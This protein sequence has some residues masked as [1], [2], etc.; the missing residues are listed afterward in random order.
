M[1]NGDDSG[2]DDSNSS[3]SDSDS[4]SDGDGSDSVDTAKDSASD[5]DDGDPGSAQ[6]LG[7]HGPG[8]AL[9]GAGA[10]M[11]ERVGEWEAHTRGIGSKLMGMMGYKRV[12][13][14]AS[15]RVAVSV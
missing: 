15:T 2:L 7:G 4:G 9:L 14:G 3:G 13:R 1:P 12:S 11:G 10:Q 5:G 6:W 8:R